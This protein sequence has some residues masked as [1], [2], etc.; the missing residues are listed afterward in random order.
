MR[1][2][3]LLS[4][5]LLLAAPVP[6]A[7]SQGQPPHAW[8]FGTWT[9]GLFPPPSSMTTQA[10]FSQPVVIF[11]RDVVMR[12]TLTEQT[13][14]QRVIESARAIPGGTEFRFAVPAATP[15][16][17]GGSDVPQAGFGCASPDDLVVQRRG[18]NEVAFPGCP[19]F[20]YP[21]VRCH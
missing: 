9:G 14:V 6:S 1:R 10:C 15:R 20:P 16:M 12:A 2:A 11:T 17:F 4:L 13:F 8:L 19:E 21:L 7:F 5:A 3:V 18:E